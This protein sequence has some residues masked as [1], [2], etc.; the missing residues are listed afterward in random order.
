MI[1]GPSCKKYS[2]RQRQ[3]EKI[4]IDKHQ[5]YQKIQKDKEGSHKDSYKDNRKDNCKDNR[6]D[7]HKDNHKNSHIDNV[8]F[9]FKIDKQDRG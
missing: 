3:Q 2:L 8:L 4:T 9:W 6:K 1:F 7:S 5:N